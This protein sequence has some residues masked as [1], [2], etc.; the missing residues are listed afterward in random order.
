MVDLRTYEDDT[1][2]DI[3]DTEFYAE[4]VE[5]IEV[6][7]PSEMRNASPDLSHVNV[8]VLVSSTLDRK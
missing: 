1:N 2:E 4:S 5:D 3:S 7:R 8:K 6:I